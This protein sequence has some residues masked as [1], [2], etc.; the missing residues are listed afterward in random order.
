[1]AKRASLSKTFVWII[2]G[3]LI[4]GL[5]G[6]GATNLSGTIRTVGHVGDKYIDVEDYGRALQQEI[7]AASAQTGQPLSFAQIQAFGLD[8]AVLN[9]LV[10]SRALDNEAAQLGISIGD[11]NLSEQIVQIPAFAGLDGTFDREGYRFALERQGLS[12]A[13][14]EDRMRDETARTLMQAAIIDGVSMPPAFTD[15]LIDYFGERRDF[16]WATLDRDALETEIASPTEDE[17]TS[18]YND[19]IDRFSLPETKQISYIWL[20]PD[21]IIDQVEVDEDALRGL[22][23]ERSNQ[24]NQPERRLVERLAFSEETA[25]NDAK[26]ALEVSGTTFEALVNDRGLEL[27]DVDLGDVTEQELED[28]GETVFAAEVGDIVGPVPS[29]LGPALFR[30]NGVLPA[31][32]TSF[33]DARAEL[34]VALAADRARRLIETQATS[35]DDML[36][37]GSTLEEVAADTDM[38]FGKIDWF[39]GIGEGIAAYVSF[40]EAATSLT[41]DDFAEVIGLEDGGMFAMQ[42]DN[43]LPQRPAPLVDVRRDVV[44]DW[45]AGQLATK[46]RAQAEALLPQIRGGADFAEVSLDAIPEE[47]LIRSNFVAGTPPE[48]MSRVFEMKPGDV[49]IVDSDGAVII[50]RLESIAPPEDSEEITALYDGVQEQTSQALAQDIFEIFA[51]DVQ[52]RGQ[53]QIDQRAINA[54]NA[55]FQHQ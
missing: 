35:I 44:A 12:E 52:L 50:V 8:R 42:L 4:L 27:S 9:R 22:Y 23:D 55:N 49:D 25:A 36:A 47:N 45:E 54:V 51:R 18:H 43:V 11:E 17:V 14:F 31:I 1:M 37:G 20:T 33:E 41:E 15:T 40:E 48:F 38:E 30:I 53:P 46:L 39:A 6:F 29:P 32:S 19:N 21:M 28:A 2:L 24:Y 26:A 5:A 7:Q 13:Q 16:T 10:T 3:L 34:Q